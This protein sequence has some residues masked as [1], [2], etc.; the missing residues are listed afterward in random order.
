L[1]PQASGYPLAQD[2][3]R[4]QRPRSRDQ[5]AVSTAAPAA[6]LRRRAAAW[7]AG[8]FQRIVGGR[9]RAIVVVL[10]A[11]VLALESADLAALG[12][13]APELRHALGISNT[14]LGLLAAVSTFVGAL[15]TVPAGALADRL[16][17]VDL[18]AVAVAL[19]GAAMIASAVAQGYGWLLFCRVG[20][21]AVTAA[22]GPIVAS[23]T[24]DFFAA[25]ERAKIYGF[26]LSGEL[27]GAGAGF[28]TAGRRKRLAATG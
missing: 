27:L 12:A 8:R 3:H 14:Q 28:V 22:A 10:L 18:L 9:P 17:R 4:K 23:L 1:R 5:S 19:W 25:S 13:A 24:G 15:A 6:R 20:L 11:C 2:A 26:I 16:R 21:G 7:A